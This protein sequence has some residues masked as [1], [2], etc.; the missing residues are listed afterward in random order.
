MRPSDFFNVIPYHASALG[1]RI[2]NSYGTP[3]TPSYN[4]ARSYRNRPVAN[5]VFTRLF[6]AGNRKLWTYFTWLKP[7]SVPYAVVLFGAGTAGTSSY[8]ALTSTGELSVTLNNT[9]YR[10]TYLKLLDPTDWVPVTIG[11]DAVNGILNVWIGLDQPA[12][13]TNAAVPNTDFQI[14][15]AD[16]HYIGNSNGGGNWADMQFADTY[17]VSG[18]L[19]GPTSFVE[20]NAEYDRVVPK[21]FVGS[22]G[23]TSFHLTYSD[24]T[25]PTTMGYDTSGNGNH[26]TPGA[27]VATTDSLLDTPTD[28]YGT[29]TSVSYSQAG[30]STTGGLTVSNVASASNWHAVRSSVAIVDGTLYAEATLGTISTDQRAYFGFCSPDSALLGTSDLGWSVWYHTYDGKVYFNFPEL[31]IAD[32]VTY[33]TAT[34]GDVIRIAYNAASRKIWVGKGST[35]FNGGDPAAG[36]GHVYQ[37]PYASPVSVATAV[38]CANA[39]VATVTVNL[40]Q[41]PFVYSDCGFDK[42]RSKRIPFNTKACDYDLVLVRNRHATLPFSLHTRADGCENYLSTN[43]TAAETADYN[44]IRRMNRGSLLVGSNSSVGGATGDRMVA[45]AFAC[46]ERSLVN[47]LGTIQSTVSRNLDLGMSIVN[48]TIPTTPANNSV[49]HGLD[50]TP[51]LILVKTRSQ[52]ALNWAVWTTG[53]AGTEYALLNSNAAKA[54]GA[55][56]WNSQVPGPQLFYIGT[57]ADVNAAA[58]ASYLALCFTSKVGFSKFGTFVGTG[59]ATIPAHVITGFKPKLLW[60]KN[61]SAAATSWLVL[62]SVRGYYNPIG[63]KTLAFNTTDAEFSGFDVDVCSNGFTVRSASASINGIGNTIFYGAFADLNALNQFG[64]GGNGR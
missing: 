25:S 6:T 5:S 21:N 20:Y 30:G 35:W 47:T 16:T 59:S 63:G 26:W 55:S 24:N 23:S 52:A 18:Q 4:I 39:A 64:I 37:L 61:L 2:G 7:N 46:R 56:Y 44:R 22:L 62:D 57:H 41:T 1:Q 31:N 12:L 58:G 15:A 60:F 33:S 10:Q 38:G 13:S 43:G 19:L 36:T 29:M 3:P 53:M 8:I 51:E 54:T 14:N 17:F 27:A 48:Y 50:D 40:G 49:G 9:V 34:T 32:S 42:L 45:Y 28:N 11:L